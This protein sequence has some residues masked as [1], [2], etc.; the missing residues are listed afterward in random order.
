MQEIYTFL[1]EHWMLSGLLLSF[2]FLFILNEA[3][4]ADSTKS[5]EVQDFIY[6]TNKPKSVIIDIRSQE[7][8]KQGH[9][10]N[11]INIPASDTVAKVLK[12]RKLKNKNIFIVC[13]TNKTCA[14]VLK[15]FE[16][17]DIQAYSLEKGLEEWQA[18][19]MPLVS[20]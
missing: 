13:D 15:D 11:S 3:N 10:V 2:I 20:K 12:D 8:Y 5:L 14:K 7:A 9:I 1:L 6:R 19:D 16:K 17:N 18:Q 4:A